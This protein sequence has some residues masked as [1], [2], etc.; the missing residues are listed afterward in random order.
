MSDEDGPLDVSVD[1]GGEATDATDAPSVDL[2]R[3][4]VGVLVANANRYGDCQGQLERGVYRQHLRVLAQADRTVLDG[5]R[6]KL[7]G[8][9]LPPDDVTDLMAQLQRLAQG[10]GLRLMSASDVLNQPDVSFLIDGWLEQRGLGVLYGP[11]GAGKSFLALQW[12][13]CIATGTDWLEHNVERG[14]VVY[15]AAEGMA[16]L[17]KRLRSLMAVHGLDR[18][19]E[20][21]YFINDAVPLLDQAV[22]AEAADLCSDI[23]P[24]LLVID[25]Y[26]RA[27]IGGDENS[28]RDSGLAIRALDELRF[29]FGMAV[30][31][32]HHT[33]KTGADERGSGALRGAAD[34]MFRLTK[35]KGAEG[36]ILKCDKQKNYEPP[37]DLALELVAD[38][39]SAHIE[40]FSG[41]SPAAGRASR[42]ARE[43]IADEILGFLRSRHESDPTPIPRGEITRAVSGRGGFQAQALND[44]VEAGA[45]ER[46]ETG[47]AHHYRLRDSPSP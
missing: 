24:A 36:L 8:V 16:G 3:Q 34:A 2:V 26:A 28:A 39:F 33:G 21:L 5:L 27:L 15:V 25:T 41:A 40:K 47:N 9:G 22:V 17:S 42:T 12:S 10:R 31:V 37:E 13:H 38:D 29:E 19:P 35:A 11:S 14:P 6:I 44:L 23:A 1:S 43:R 45:I 32:L 4:A 30:L 18:P 7:K 20:A 46:I